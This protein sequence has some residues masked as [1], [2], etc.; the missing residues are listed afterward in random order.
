MKL[1]SEFRLL[2]TVV[3]YPHRIRSYWR[4]LN[5]NKIHMKMYDIRYRFVWIRVT[6]AACKQEERCQLISIRQLFWQ[7]VRTT[8]MIGIVAVTA[9]VMLPSALF[10]Y[11]YLRSPHAKGWLNKIVHLPRWMT[12]TCDGHCWIVA[13]STTTST[14]SCQWHWQAV[15]TI[16]IENGKFIDETQLNT[17]IMVKVE[18]T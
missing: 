2:C 13:I 4:V 11:L 6:D 15:W 5:N 9:V 10:V 14:S 18:V 3:L 12:V 17:D 16:L 7:L 8:K 1:P